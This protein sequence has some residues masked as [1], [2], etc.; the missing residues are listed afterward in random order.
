MVLLQSPEFIDHLFFCLF[1]SSSECKGEDSVTQTE[2]GIFAFEGHTVTLNCTFETSSTTQTLFWYRQDLQDFPKYMLK[3]YLGTV[4]N[5]PEFNKDR[6]IAAT[7]GKL[8]PLEIQNL[9]LSDSAVYYCALQPTVT[10]NTK[11][12]YKNH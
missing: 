9:H 8:F 7:N 4:E 6:F 3:S 12:L 11:A 10:G 2:G 5:A 1:S